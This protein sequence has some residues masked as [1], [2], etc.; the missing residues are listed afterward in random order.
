MPKEN[1][2]LSALWLLLEGPPNRV[3]GAETEGVVGAPNEK[4]GLLSTG[5]ATVGVETPNVN[6]DFAGV[7][8]DGAAGA[9]EPKVKPPLPP[10]DV[11]GKS[12]L[13]ASTVGVEVEGGTAGCPK[14]NNFGASAPVPAWLP[15]K[16]DGDGAGAP[17]IEGLEGAGA[18]NDGCFG[19]SFVPNSGLASAGFAGSLLG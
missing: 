8:G 5:V 15:P 11:E 1:G 2:L 16:G 13:G 10:E 12:G 4:A 18:P 9:E 6:G 3:V 17:N 19:G 14:V 7:D